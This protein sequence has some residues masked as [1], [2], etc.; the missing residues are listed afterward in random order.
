VLVLLRKNLGP[1]IVVTIAG[2][3]VGKSRV[4]KTKVR[5]AIYRRELHGHH[6]LDLRRGGE[7]RHLDQPVRLESQEAAV[8]WVTFSL[9][10]RLE[11]N[12]ALIAGSIKTDP[13]AA[14]QRSN[15][16]V[17]ARYKAIGGARIV[18]SAVN[19]SGLD[20]RSGRQIVAVMNDAVPTTTLWH[21]INDQRDSLVI[22]DDE[23]TG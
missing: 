18:R 5:P 4:A 19:A 12:G 6:R 14:N 13:G 1:G 3:L 11:K 20:D 2:F 17:H 8:V 15:C 16:S 9:V 7:P 23:L 21:V 22:S 10:V